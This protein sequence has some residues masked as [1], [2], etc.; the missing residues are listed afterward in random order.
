MKIICNFTSKTPSQVPKFSPIQITCTNFKEVSQENK[1]EKK[2]VK[3]NVG[4]QS[5]HPL[6][7]LLLVAKGASTE[8]NKKK[9]EIRHCGSTTVGF[10]PQP[11]DQEM[12]QE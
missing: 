8:L 10:D 5:R 9:E 11:L 6:Y 12:Q 1:E 2:C 7:C 3:P 4:L